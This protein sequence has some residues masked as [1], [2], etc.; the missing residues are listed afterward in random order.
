M[1]TELKGRGFDFLTDARADA[2][3][4]AAYQEINDLYDWPWLEATTSGA[5]PLTVADFGKAIYV[6]DTTG[7]RVLTHLDPI[8]LADQFG[9]A[10]PSTAGSPSYYWLDGTSIIKVYPVQAVTLSVRYF[11]RPTV[12]T[13]PDTP[14]VPVA[15]HLTIVSM[16]QRRAA[17]LDEAEIDDTA[18]LKQEID[19]DLGRM[20][21]AYAIRSPDP[22]YMRV[23]VN[24]SEDW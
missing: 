7:S 20:V 13:A 9:T 24:S 15:Y 12:L 18:L 1:R 4:N 17:G 11:K 21:Q 19:A 23:S 8:L 10:F 5:A 6:H 22:D 2:Y 14:I 16:A 3:L